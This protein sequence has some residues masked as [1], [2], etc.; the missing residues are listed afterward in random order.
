[1]TE[2]AQDLI[3][4]TRGQLDILNLFFFNSTTGMHLQDELCEA[5]GETFA[6]MNNRL[7]KIE[8]VLE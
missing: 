5:L 7:S 8:E 3:Q 4:F 6:D 2:T 1:M